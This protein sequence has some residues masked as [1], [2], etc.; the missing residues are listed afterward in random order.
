MDSRTRALDLAET[1]GG[2]VEVS[3]D[4]WVQVAG[5]R[6]V[7]VTWDNPGWYFNLY[8]TES[9]KPVREGMIHGTVEDVKA[10]IAEARYPLT[11]GERFTQTSAR[12]WTDD[13]GTKHTHTVVSRCE[14]TQRDAAGFGYTVVETLESTD[15]PPRQAFAASAGTMAWFGFTAAVERGDITI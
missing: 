2:T 10:F 11:V 3:G 4:V 9:E 15:A 7:A 5:G 1:L 14:V 12:R 8:D 13:S 6:Y